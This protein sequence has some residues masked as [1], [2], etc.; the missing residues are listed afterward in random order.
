M[1]AMK[2]VAVGCL[3]SVMCTAQQSATG[4]DKDK[5]SNK[6][7]DKPGQVSGGDRQ[8]NLKLL[9]LW[10]E[11]PVAVQRLYEEAYKI[12]AAKPGASF[13]DLA[14]DAGIQRLAAEASIT[15]FGGP[16]LGSLRPDGAS[17]WLRTLRP[18]RV[19]VRVQVDGQE[20]IFGPVESTART[21]L[22]AV[23]PVTGLKPAGRYPYRVFVDGKPITMPATAVIVTPQA[24]QARIAFGSCFHRWGLGNQNQSAQIRNRGATAFLTIGDIAVQDR[25][26]NLGMHRA[27]YLLRDFFPAWQD[28]AAAVPI[29]ATW[30][31]HDYFRNDGWGLP[32]G[33]TDAD[34]RGVWDVFRYAWNNPSYGF[35]DERRGIFLR[36]RIGPADIILVDHRY[37]RTPRSDDAAASGNFLGPE[38]MQWLEAELLDCRGPFIILSCGTMWGDSVSD[39]KD[40]WGKFDPAGREQIFQLIEKHRIPGVLL[41]SGDRHGARVF[42]IPRAG[43]FSFYEFEPASLGGRGD[44]PAATNANWKDQVFGVVGKY[45]FGEF[46]FDAA[47]PDPEVVFRLIDDDGA[48]LHEL[49]LTR[50]QLTP[51]PLSTRG[52]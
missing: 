4:Q 38:Q 16:M 39:G 2:I 17:V 22:S 31:D 50:S 13:A 14:A 35:N 6:R 30:D 1:S 5:G 11:R 51:P 40:S 32:K 18:A 21:D 19:E 37:F 43:G 9:N 44:G 28:L 45:A 26:A 24:D 20:K 29:Y 52:S 15:H 41:I 42:R 34:R 36:T 49:K 46:T 23:V 48:T 8:S 7:R 3:L 10:G 25:N 27:D 12:L 33:S 47:R